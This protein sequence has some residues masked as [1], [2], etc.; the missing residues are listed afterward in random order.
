MDLSTQPPKFQTEF[1]A[2]VTF[3]ARGRRLPA[4]A[5]EGKVYVSGYRPIDLQNIVAKGCNKGVQ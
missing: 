3:V 5:K 2:R 4:P 1:S